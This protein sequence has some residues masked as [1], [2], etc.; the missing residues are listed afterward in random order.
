MGLT[1]HTAPTVTVATPTNGSSLTTTTPTFSG[2]AGNALGDSTTVNVTI[3]KQSDSSV[4]RT[5]AVTR[6]GTSWSVAAGDWASGSPTTLADGTYKVTATQTDWASNTG[7]SN[8]N[9]FTVDTNA[10][11]TVITEPGQR[12]HPGQRRHRVHR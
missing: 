10:P 6:S 5:F 4:V 7:T 11:T 2:T 8:T 9:N 12:L 3:R 1:D